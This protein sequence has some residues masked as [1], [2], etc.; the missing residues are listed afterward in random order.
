MSMRYVMEIK[1]KRK[2]KDKGRKKS[3]GGKPNNHPNH[4]NTF[5]SD[6]NLP[7]ERAQKSVWRGSVTTP[8]THS[9]ILS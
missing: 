8:E 2:K 7:T 9:W 3:S 4:K 5:T 1:K 6:R